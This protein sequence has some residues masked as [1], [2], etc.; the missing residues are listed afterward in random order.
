MS[1]NP[2]IPLATDQVSNSQSA[3]LGNFGT[4]D[5]GTSLTGVGFARNHVTMTD[6]TNGGLHERV[7]FYQAL[8]DP[9]ISGFVGSSYVK[10]VVQGGL[11]A[12]PQLCF[13]TGT[14]YLL[15][16]ALSAAATGFTY[17]PGGI[18]LKWGDF[19]GSSGVNTLTFPTGASIPVFA[20]IYQV[21]LCTFNAPPSPNYTG[22]VQTIAT[23]GFVYNS[24]SIRSTGGAPGDYCYL[25]IGN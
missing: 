22:F 16:G 6:G 21:F 23:T 8:S 1:Y 25:A 2:S 15:S 10:S 17:L 20:H 11:A 9:V 7:D 18:L 12:A 3:I 14:P 5:P 13:N 19:T 24:T 4:I